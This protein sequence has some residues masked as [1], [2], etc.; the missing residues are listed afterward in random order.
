MPVGVGRL[1]A[2]PPVRR[3]AFFMPPAASVGAPLAAILI[4]CIFL[5]RLAVSVGEVSLSLS[6]LVGYGALLVLLLRGRLA[7]SL[8]LGIMFMAVMALLTLSMVRSGTTASLM[9]FFYLFSIYGLYL[10]KLRGGERTAAEV[11]ELFQRLML[12]A[13]ACGIAQFCLQFVLPLELVF[14]LESFVPEAFKFGGEFYNVVIPLTYGAQIYKSNGVFFLEPSFFSQFLALAVLIELLGRQRILRLAVYAGGLVVAYSGTGLLLIALFLPYV[15]LRRGNLHLLLFGLA[16][17]ALLAVSATALNLDTVT[18]RIGEFGSEES[19]GFARFVSPFYLFRDFM[20]TADAFFFG[21]GPG[22]ILGIMKEASYKGYVSHDPTWIKAL[23][24]YGVIAGLLLIAYTAMAF[25]VGPASRP[26]A[27]AI[28]A[29][30]LFMGGYLLNPVMHFLFAALLA[31]P[32]SRLPARAQA[33]RGRSLA[34]AAGPHAAR[35]GSPSST[36]AR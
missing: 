13:A 18:G 25:V 11:H 17:A 34:M 15:L 6:F 23:M 7:V 27:L 5:Q 3:Q 21:H 35:W 4:A 36:N 8:P 12:F 20:G 31:W 26:F 16:A 1:P 14:P 10:F 33:T 19:S 9:S 2:H 24:E 28:L 30:F 29:L 22:S 32:N